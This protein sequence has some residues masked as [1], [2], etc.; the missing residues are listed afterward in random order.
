M[1]EATPDR[2]ADPGSLIKVAKLTERD[3]RVLCLLAEGMSNRQIATA[4]GLTPYTVL[5]SINAAYGELRVHSRA[6]LRVWAREHGLVV[7]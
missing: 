7:T 2:L 5:H 6:E 1:I 3:K 4:L